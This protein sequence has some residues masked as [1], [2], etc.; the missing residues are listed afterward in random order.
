MQQML[1]LLGATLVMTAASLLS[2]HATDRDHTGRNVG[3]VT[4]CSTNGHFTC[5]SAPVRTGRYGKVMRLNG[6]T[7]ISCEG[8]CRDTLRKET[9][10]FW[11]EQRLNGG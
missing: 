4:A 1:G 5:Y 2:A 9:V 7:W 10:D 11:D 6:G 8:D 3:T